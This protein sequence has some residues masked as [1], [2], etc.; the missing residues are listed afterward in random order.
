MYVRGG[1]QAH[2]PTGLKKVARKSA[3]GEQREKGIIVNKGE[4]NSS[5][6]LRRKVNLLIIIAEI[7]VNWD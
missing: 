7:Q 3:G 6:H 4:K 5:N 1:Q 2:R